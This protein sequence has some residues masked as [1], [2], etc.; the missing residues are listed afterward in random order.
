MTLLN[1]QIFQLDVEKNL[2]G[3]FTKKI[4]LKFRLLHLIFFKFKRNWHD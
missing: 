3:K 1:I 4:P 2:K